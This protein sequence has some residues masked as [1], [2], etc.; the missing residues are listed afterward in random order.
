MS[1]IAHLKPLTADCHI[2]R[3]ETYNLFR[4]CRLR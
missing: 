2:T 4:R 3:L 1:I